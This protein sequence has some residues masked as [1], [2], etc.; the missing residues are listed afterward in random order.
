MISI[1]YDLLSINVEGSILSHISIASYVLIGTLNMQASKELYLKDR[2]NVTWKNVIQVVPEDLG[3]LMMGVVSYCISLT[4]F[5][6]SY[7]LS[8]QLE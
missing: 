4:H 1:E 7:L 5:L 8:I 2:R 3:S 6:I